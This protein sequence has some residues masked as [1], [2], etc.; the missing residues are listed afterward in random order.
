MK[1]VVAL[2]L[3]FGTL[4]CGMLM[5]AILIR[6]VTAIGENI[7]A[8]DTYI[9]SNNPTVNYGTD[10]N[11]KA[12]I[13]SPSTYEAYFFF[14]FPQGEATGFSKVEIRIYYSSV[15]ADVNITTCTIGQDWDETGLTW[16]NKPPH[17]LVISTNPCK[18][19]ATGWIILD[20][21][22]LFQSAQSNISICLNASDNT[23]TGSILSPSRGFTQT[24]LR[25]KIVWLFPADAWMPY[26]FYAI[27]AALIII[28]T[29][30]LVKYVRRRKSQPPEPKV[31]KSHAAVKQEAAGPEGSGVS[32][33]A[34]IEKLKK[35]IQVSQK[36]KVA[37]IAK[38]LEMSEDDLYKRIVDWA[39]TFGFTLNE[40]VVDFGGGGKKDA[41]IDALEKEFKTWGKSTEKV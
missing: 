6:G 1:H 34:R 16:N 10:Y 9:D 15:T 8:K 14:N 19:G 27:F 25:P 35:L 30:L 31:E 20:V 24:D 38:I 26:V 23:Q 28:P 37:Q 17:G 5:P 29:I 41:F 32:E 22:S 33:S 39:A 21:T 36:M 13:S 11:C 4:I 7:A 18:V 3:L 12:G 2:N 40:D